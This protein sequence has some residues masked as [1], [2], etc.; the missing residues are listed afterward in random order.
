MENTI[1]VQAKVI[2]FIFHKCGY[3][4]QGPLGKFH[5]VLWSLDIKVVI[6]G[7]QLPRIQ[8][9]VLSGAQEQCQFRFLLFLDID[10]TGEMI[11]T[12]T[13]NQF[14]RIAGDGVEI[15]VEDHD[16]GNVI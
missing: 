14:L 8:D 5:A 9:Q 13:N 6:A 11:T 1:Q 16:D 15:S 7:K 3:F 2:S 12:I 4:H 10:D